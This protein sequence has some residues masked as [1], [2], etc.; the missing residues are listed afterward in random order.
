MRRNRMREVPGAELLGVMSRAVV[1]EAVT[2]LFSS[3]SSSPSSS[4]SSSSSSS[5][6]SSPSMSQQ[7]LISRLR[8]RLLCPTFL[9]QSLGD[10][11]NNR[12]ESGIGK[13]GRKVYHSPMLLQ[14]VLLLRYIRQGAREGSA[15]PPPRWNLAFDEEEKRRR[16]RRRS[17][18]VRRPLRVNNG[19]TSV[20][21]NEERMTDTLSRDA[22]F[23]VLLSLPPSPSPPPPP[24]PFHCLAGD[25]DSSST[26]NYRDPHQHPCLETAPH[27]HHLSSSS[28]FPSS[29][30]SSS[31]S[32]FSSS[33]SAQR[34]PMRHR[35]NVGA[36]SRIYALLC[37][38]HRE[39]PSL[40]VMEKRVK[41]NNRREVKV[42]A[43]SRTRSHSKRRGERGGRERRRGEM[44]Y[45]ARGSQDQWRRRRHGK[46][47][48]DLHLGTATEHFIASLLRRDSACVPPSLRPTEDELF[49]VEE[50]EE[51]E[52]GGGGGDEEDN[53]DDDDVKQEQEEGE[54][55]D[56]DHR[57]RQNGRRRRRRKRNAW[58]G[59]R[60]GGAHGP[61]A[62]AMATERQLPWL[63][64]S[65]RRAYVLSHRAHVT[66]Q[67]AYRRQAKHDA[68]KT[69]SVAREEKARKERLKRVQR[70]EEE[71][72]K[73]EREI[74][75]TNAVKMEARRRVVEHYQTLERELGGAVH[76]GVRKARQEEDRINE[77]EEG[78]E[79]SSRGNEENEKKEDEKQVTSLVLRRLKLGQVLD[80]EH[81]QLQKEKNQV[82]QEEQ[83][84]EEGGGGGEEE[85]EEE[86]GGGGGER[87]KEEEDDE[88]EED[89]HDDRKGSQR[90]ARTSG[91]DG[92]GGKQK[93][94]EEEEK[95]D[96]SHHH[97]H[98]H[99]HHHPSVETT[100]ERERQVV[101]VTQPPRWKDERRQPFYVVALSFRRRENN[102]RGRRRREGGSRRRRRRRG[103]EE[104]RRR[105]T[106]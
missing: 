33:S 2:T 28:S 4:S 32:S 88:D 45:E 41:G 86:D 94:E 106:G 80:L 84:K 14:N 44:I 5:P 31:S 97:Y 53:N 18:M 27:H 39:I 48:L 59:G 21:K 38:E 89:D 23:P 82:V 49:G 13:G 25:T 101:R 35:G 98:H 37:T 93:L 15:L 61:I 81:R 63:A 36:A 55:D 66:R 85:E 11:E 16:R 62:A 58:G 90:D 73:E 65:I 56:H 29:T 46:T 6:S 96:I 7:W 40:L 57:R 104:R 3:S 91:G 47:T 68:F 100:F 1:E 71:R 70:E 17:R 69:V 8:L 67:A 51:E 34:P 87:N 64:E 10:A 72:E 9:V 76:A 42:E 60:A 20:R 54:Y 102:H 75:R 12:K 99:H 74:E 30:S 50:E 105:Q 83:K 26:A 79:V 103:S 77:M 78:G 95:R 52:G 24:P 92:A 19:S 43:P 22:S